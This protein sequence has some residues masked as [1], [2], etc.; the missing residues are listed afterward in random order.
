MARLVLASLLSL[1]MGP[2]LAAE[3]ADPFAGDTW[4]AVKGS[5]P[6]TI[7]FDGKT[8]KV[9]LSPVGSDVIQATYSYTVKPTNSAAVKSRVKAKKFVAGTLK[10]RNTLGQVSLSEFT[11]E[12]KELTLRMQGGMQIEHYLRM[13]K[14]EEKA[15]L[16]RIEKLVSEGKLKLPQ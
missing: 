9:V 2:A 14:A 12:G 8:K 16:L 7:E 10:M 15:E 3:P 6:G 4:H 13:T 11:I 5:W 1:T